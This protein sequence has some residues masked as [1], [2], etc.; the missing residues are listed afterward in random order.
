MTFNI[1]LDT[2]ADSL[3]SWAYRR[4]NAAQMIKEADVDIVGMQEVLIHQLNDLKERLPEYSSVG[5]GRLDG[6]E[7]GEF[8]PVFYREDQFEEVESGN[9]WLSEDPA[10]VGVKGWDAA[11]ERIASWAILKDKTSGKEFFVLSTHFDHIGQVARRESA[12]LILSKTA[13]LSDG[14]P[15]IVMGDF[16]ADPESEVIQTIADTANPLSLIHSYS[17][18][19][20]VNGSTYTFHNYGRLAEEDRECIDYIFV[21][22]KVEVAEYQVMPERNE[23]GYFSDHSAVR[24]RIIIN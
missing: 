4:D 21:N 17:L 15:V 11:C 10:A 1:R 7:A 18:A 13:E 16:N 2:P 14:L 23:A 22:N 9:F 12:R 20:I 8:S 3:N 6:K 24:V 5:V 19:P